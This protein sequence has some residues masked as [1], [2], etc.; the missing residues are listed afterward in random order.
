[1][2]RRAAP[3]RGLVGQAHVFGGEVVGA[4]GMTL[5]NCRRRRVQRRHY[6][7]GAARDQCRRQSQ[8][9]CRFERQT[10]ADQSAPARRRLGHGDAAVQRRVNPLADINLGVPRCPMGP[11][12]TR[13]RLSAA[14][15]T[16]HYPLSHRRLGSVR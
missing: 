16:A 14:A 10:T 2:G 8:H 4:A 12:A 13:R 6:A 11:E 1:V 3:R 5:N 9:R 15:P 7:A